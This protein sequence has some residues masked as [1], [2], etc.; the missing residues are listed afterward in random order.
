M[1]RRHVLF[2]NR[3]YPPDRAATGHMLADLA[4]GL[5]RRGW[6]V[7]VVV[8]N[9]T[10]APSRETLDGVEVHRV[11]GLPFTRASALRRALA[12]LSLYPGLFWRAWR[13]ADVD[14]VVT[15]TDPPLVQLLGALLPRPA[16]HWAQDIYPELAV[17]LGVL[18]PGMAAP[19]RALS[20][21]CLRR[22]RTVV[23]IG[24]CM[25]ERL[26]VRGLDRAC[27]AVVP[28]WADTER[29]R[30]IDAGGFRAEHGLHGPVVM[31]SGNLG[32]AHP[33][34]AML[35]AAAALPEAT[36]VFV[37]DGPRLGWVRDQ[38]QRRGLANVRFLP[39]Q[40]LERLAESLSAADLHLAS[41]EPH[42][43]GL[44]VPSKVYGI[45]AA[46]RPCLF[47]GPADSEAARLIAAH[48]C[49]E[50]LAPDAD[51]AASIRAWLD[52]PARREEAGNRARAAAEAGGL[53]AA[54]DAFDRLLTAAT[55][56]R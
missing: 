49:G 41:M 40:P 23:A 55:R 46:G 27:I 43:A 19:L 48:G 7:S 32:L 53:P 37:G 47:L 10:A 2:L 42:L 45:L 6:R 39:F 4:R 13:I 54:L 36:I 9:T 22:H 17:E 1:S 24:R 15:K 33:F 31:Y 38:V 30:P 8:A 12:Y 29:V 26:A 56:R 34:G 44:V 18:K 14:V 28:N 50:V 35:D 3:V 20:T 25:A 5:V 16:V 51:L 52:D 11:A 21:W